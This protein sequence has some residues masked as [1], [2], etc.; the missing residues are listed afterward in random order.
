MQGII[1][2]FNIEKEYGF[3]VPD[4]GSN[5]ILLQLTECPIIGIEQKNTKRYRVPREGETLS[6]EVVINS[7]GNYKATNITFND[8]NNEFSDDGEI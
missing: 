3:I 6:F 2:F 5:D 4:D 1:K 8:N 7:D